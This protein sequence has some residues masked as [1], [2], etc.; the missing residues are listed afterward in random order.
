MAVEAYAMA[1]L[2]K[3]GAF[4]RRSG[5]GET[6]VGEA[7]GDTVGE[8]VAIGVDGA[9]GD[10]VG[11]AVRDGVGEAVAADVGT[12]VGVLECPELT[13]KGKWTRNAA[14]KFC[15]CAPAVLRTPNVSSGRK[16]AR[17]ASTTVRTSM[18]LAVARMM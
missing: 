15:A 8:A 7:V 17:T 1:P 10:A 3:L 12:G 6:D 14:V 5:A 2:L 18:N 13:T 9:V 11:E 4:T 16:T